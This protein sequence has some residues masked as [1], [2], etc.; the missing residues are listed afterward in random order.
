M[1]YQ[2]PSRQARGLGT[3]HENIRKRLIGQHVQGT[4]CWWCG[5][6]MYREAEANFDG[7]PLHADHSTARVKGGLDADRLLHGR[8]NSERGDGSRDHL[9]PVLADRDG[10]VRS[11][12][13]GLWTRQWY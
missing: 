12:A 6:P 4:P 7:S 13:S 8:C 1:T 2:K 3:R 5:K 10:Q 11:V 9:R